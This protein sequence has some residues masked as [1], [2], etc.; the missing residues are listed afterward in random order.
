MICLRKTKSL[1][2]FSFVILVIITT[3]LLGACTKNTPEQTKPKI[4]AKNDRP[5]APLNTVKEEWKLPISIQEGE[6]YKLAGWLSDS[7]VVY[8]TN[9][10]QTSNVYQYNLGTGKS[11]LMYKSDSPIV[12]VQISPFKKYL[13]IHSSP[14]SY[15]GLMTIIDTKGTEI[16]KAA[17]PSYDLV[18]E[19]NPY[20]ESKVLVSKFNEDWTF[21]VLE[22]NIKD[23]KQTE[24][25][26]SQPFL[27]WIDE[28][29]IAFLNWDDENPSLSAPLI[30]KGLENH[31][32]KT[33]FSDVF[34]FSAFRN[35]LMTV[36]VQGQDQTK[37]VYSFFD[38][39]LKEI[40]TFSTPILSRFSGWLVPFNDY[41]EAKK[42]FITLRPLESEEADSYT[43]GFELVSYELEKQSSTVI[44]DGLDNQPIAISPSGDALLYGNS[45]EKIIDLKSKKIVEI[46]KE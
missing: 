3:L 31:V 25:N 6:F 38:N 40:F 37:A 9:Q 22:F 18:F 34:Q 8:I 41:N 29:Q 46:I 19:W 23:S 24:L 11:E 27:K 10:E 14:S 16:K 28:K 42:K 45:L 2:G 32:E 17:I 33:V 13:L 43:D 15:E 20:D 4:P 36:S 26:L 21:Q 7:V 39:G 1:C 30:I 44:M 35:L 5:K 12:T